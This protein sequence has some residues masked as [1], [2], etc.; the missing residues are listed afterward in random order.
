M[1]TSRDLILVE[2]R[3]KLE[4]IYKELNEEDTEIKN[5]NLELIRKAI[6]ISPPIAFSLTFLKINNDKSNIRFTSFYR[7]MCFINFW[8]LRF[9]L[10][11]YLKVNNGEIYFNK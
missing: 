11:L 4:K 9:K 2:E 5:W 6:L 1:K 8:W 7:Y 10:S 3:K